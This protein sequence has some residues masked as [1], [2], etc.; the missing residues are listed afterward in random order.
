MTALQLGASLDTAAA[1]KLRHDLLARLDT[2]Q[3]LTIDGAEVVRVGQAC[4]QLLASARAAAEA[5]QLTFAIVDPSQPLVD[6]ATLAGL[7]AILEP[8]G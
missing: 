8:V 7:G 2:R 6:M 5:Q 4:L 1:T 3:P